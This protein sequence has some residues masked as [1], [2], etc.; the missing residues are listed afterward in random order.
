MGKMSRQRSSSLPRGYLVGGSASPV[1]YR[2]EQDPWQSLYSRLRASASD[3]IYSNERR[4]L[5]NSFL[6]EARDGEAFEA[7]IHSSERQPV[8]PPS[9]PESGE[10][11]CG[12]SCGSERSLLSIVDVSDSE[13][14]P[15][16]SISNRD[17]SPSEHGCN[18]LFQTPPGWCAV[19]SC[20]T[21]EEFF[22]P[23]YQAWMQVVD[24]RVCMI[25]ATYCESHSHAD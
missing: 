12:Y 19:H 9:F 21:S 17:P 11:K 20:Y 14:D 5:R 7:A 6:E 15:Q 23:E 22:D 2:F 1:G 10:S 24:P 13:L 8:M 16:D 3:V 18:W 25:G 4:S